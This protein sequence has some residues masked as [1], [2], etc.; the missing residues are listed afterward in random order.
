MSVCLS[1]CLPACLPVCHA[2]GFENRSP[3]GGLLP[4]AAGGGGGGGMVG[5]DGDASAAALQELQRRKPASEA[6]REEGRLRDLPLS[7]VDA[8]HA[9]VRCAMCGGGGGG[10]GA[11]TAC[12]MAPRT[13]QLAGAGP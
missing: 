7:P 4:T 6:L 1:I 8:A 12:A 11:P 10:G 13:P 3:G 5:G 2:Q 9:R